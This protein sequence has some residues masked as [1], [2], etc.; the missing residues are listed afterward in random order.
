M[1]NDDFI[2][3]GVHDDN[4]EDCVVDVYDADEDCIDDDDEGLKPEVNLKDAT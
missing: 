2:W 4:D 1:S 3:I